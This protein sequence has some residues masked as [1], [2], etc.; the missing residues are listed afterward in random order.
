ML[1]LSG[2][3]NVSPH[4]TLKLSVETFHYP[5]LDVVIFRGKEVHSVIFHK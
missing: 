4:F 5:G 1:L 3:S 2:V